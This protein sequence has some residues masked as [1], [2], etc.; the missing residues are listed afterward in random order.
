MIRSYLQ[1]RTFSVIIEE[2]RSQQKPLKYGVPQG[3]ILGP[4]FYLLYT[5][6]IEEIVKK[7]DIKAHIYADDCSIYLS[8]IPED[9]NAA[10][11]RYKRCFNELQKWMMVSFLK[12][13]R[14]KTKLKI[15]RP[16]NLTENTDFF[17]SNSLNVNIE[18]TNTV[19][20]LGVTLGSKFNFVEFVNKKIQSC[21][22]HLRNLRAVKSSISD[23]AIILLGCWVRLAAEPK[24]FR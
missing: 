4:L 6:G 11:E 12:L 19:K 18:P 17:V 16:N 2:Q 15:F 13:N 10:A 1:N 22:F 8:Y 3:S 21:N 14:D 5:K 20:L 24:M 7:Y 23:E 9:Q